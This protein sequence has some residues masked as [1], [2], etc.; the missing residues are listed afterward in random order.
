MARFRECN[1]CARMLPRR[2]RFCP[3]CG[4]RRRAGG[5]GWVWL[6]SPF[7]FFAFFGMFGVRYHS[8]NVAP[9]QTPPI[10]NANSHY[11]PKNLQHNQSNNE[12]RESDDNDR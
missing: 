2:A 11:W 7:L 5:W 6:F 1:R 8:A 10:V 3:Q 9:N 12:T 4:E